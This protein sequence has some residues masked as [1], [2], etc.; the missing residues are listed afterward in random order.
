MMRGR[1]TGVSVAYGEGVDRLIALVG[2]DQAP[3]VR[4]EGDLGRCSRGRARLAQRLRR[5][6]QRLQVSVVADAEP[7]DGFTV[8]VQ[9]V[10]DPVADGDADGQVAPA[11]SDIAAYEATIGDG[12]CRHSVVA[13]V[14][15][16][17]Q[18]AVTHQSVLRSK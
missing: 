5:V 8:L 18:V 9:D 15:R 7:A 11:G 3:A 12:E 13:A 4:S 17:Q 2:D 6:R 10:H 14:H 1:G 16:E